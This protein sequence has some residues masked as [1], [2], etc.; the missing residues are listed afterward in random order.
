MALAASAGTVADHEGTFG[1]TA[2]PILAN[3]RSRPCLV[4]GFSFGIH[5]IDAEWPLLA[6]SRRSKLLISG[7]LNGRFR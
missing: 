1:D 5:C 4:F 2:S 7:E 3:D 6:E